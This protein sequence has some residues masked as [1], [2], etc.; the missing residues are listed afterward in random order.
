MRK[1]WAVFPKYHPFF[2]RR[3][4][5]IVIF[6][7][8][9]GRGGCGQEIENRVC[10]QL[11]TLPGIGGLRTHPTLKSTARMAVAQLKMYIVR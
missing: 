9:F 5:E 6:V 3:E 11:H 8:L 10:N 7:G 1:I 2:L 4:K